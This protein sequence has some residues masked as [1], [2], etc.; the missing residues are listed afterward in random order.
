MKGLLYKDLCTLVSRYRK[1]FLLLFVVYLGMAMLMELPFMLYALVFVLG[2]YV[3]SAVG[4]DEFSHWDIYAQIG[5]AH[6]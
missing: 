5:R 3:Q 4:F 2:L 6:V 1:N